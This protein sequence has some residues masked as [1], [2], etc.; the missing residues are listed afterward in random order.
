M[1]CGREQ[2]AGLVKNLFLAVFFYPV[3]I[4]IAFK[5]K[6]DYD[7]GIHPAQYNDKGNN[8]F[9]RVFFKEIHNTLF[10]IFRICLFLRFIV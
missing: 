1:G 8:Y 4:L 3:L 5:H 7:A 10:N 2:G 6:S 9:R